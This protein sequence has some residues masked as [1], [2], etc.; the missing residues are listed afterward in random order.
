PAPRESIRQIRRRRALGVVMTGC[1]PMRPRRRRALGVLAVVSAAALSLASCSGGTA[2]D[3]AAGGHRVV[4]WAV[5]VEPDSMDVAVNGNAAPALGLVMD[6]MERLSGDGSLTPNLAT[7]VTTP[8]DTTIVYHLRH[9]VRFS[10]GAPLTAEDA[11]WSLNHDNAPTSTSA[12][13]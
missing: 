7:A 8:D 10:N 11:A 13:T 3:P 6:Q 5:G 1:P 4:T 12:L 2:S 9:N